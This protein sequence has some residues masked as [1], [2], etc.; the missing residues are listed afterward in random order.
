MLQCCHC[1]RGACEGGGRGEIEGRSTQGRV[2]FFY[3][4]CF[5]VRFLRWVVEIVEHWAPPPPSPRLSVSARMDTLCRE[6]SLSVD[7]SVRI[8]KKK[9]KVNCVCVYARVHASGRTYPFA[10]TW[11]STRPQLFHPGPNAESPSSYQDVW[12]VVSTFF[13]AGAERLRALACFTGPVNKASPLGGRS[14]A[15]MADCRLGGSNALACVSLSLV[16]SACSISIYFV[17]NRARI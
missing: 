3:V 17:T 1:F 16:P 6:L 2:F 4:C 12:N 9:K 7:L 8:K 11:K 13:T 10:G 15:E 5:F 14:A